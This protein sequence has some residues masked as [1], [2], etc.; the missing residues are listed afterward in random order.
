MIPIRTTRGVRLCATLVAFGLLNACSV[1]PGLNSADKFDVNDYLQTGEN[2]GAESE[3]NSLAEAASLCDLVAFA[4]TWHPQVRAAEEAIRSA[5]AQ[6]TVAG[7]W[8]DPQV[9]VSQGLNDSNWQTLSVEQEIPTFGRR[10]LQI[11]QARAQWESAK[12]EKEQ[13]QATVAVNVQ[14]AWAEYA[15]L[16]ANL[17]ILSDQRALLEQLVAVVDTRYRNGQAPVNELLRTQN[18]LDQVNTE[19]RNLE[20]LRTSATARMNSALGR[21]AMAELPQLPELEAEAPHYFELPASQSDLH[22]LAQQQNP[23]LRSAYFQLESLHHQRGIANR[24]GLPRLM[25]GAEYM[26]TAMASNTVTGMASVSLPVWR[27]GYRAQRESA[28]ASL[29]AE[30]GRYQ[31]LTLDISAE[32]SIAIYGWQEANRNR[33]LFGDVLVSRAEQSIESA[34]SAYQGGTGDYANLLESQREWLAFSLNYNRALADLVSNAATILNLTGLSDTDSTETV[35]E[36]S[37]D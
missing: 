37:N 5:H 21:P 34:L 10:Q 4:Q 27:S 7:T 25:L 9:S 22:E 35:S 11:E 6:I 12:A 31:S 26:D 3:F 1:S 24:A 14:Q 23:S 17:K 19:L 28:D 30:A 2:S 18:E 32:L 8:S 36:V 20:Q 33:A 15:Y 16:N 13:V 29:R